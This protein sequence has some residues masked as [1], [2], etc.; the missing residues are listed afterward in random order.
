MATNNKQ[1]EEE[2][3]EHKIRVVALEEKFYNLEKWEIK[4]A[5]RI[6]ILEEEIDDY[7]KILKEEEGIVFEKL[8]K[9]IKE[10]EKKIETI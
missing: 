7:K 2:I 9:K 4:N 3:I 8:N 10:L 1:K 6:K 5:K